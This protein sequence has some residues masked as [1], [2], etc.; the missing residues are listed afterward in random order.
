MAQQAQWLAEAVSVVE[1]CGDAD[2]EL[3]LQQGITSLEDLA[4][5]EPEML[6]QIP[7]IDEAGANAIKVR[8]AELAEQRRREEEEEAA[9]LEAERAE[10]ARAEATETAAPGQGEGSGEAQSEG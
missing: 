8:A 5:C 4:A 10:A 6:T 3:L 9:R 1:G 7:G 2:A